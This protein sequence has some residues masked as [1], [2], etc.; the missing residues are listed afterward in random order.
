MSDRVEQVGNPLL[1][2]PNGKSE[3]LPKSA[4]QSFWQDGLMTGNLRAIV[5][6]Q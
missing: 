2:H 6:A 5:S 3:I 1:S 4:T